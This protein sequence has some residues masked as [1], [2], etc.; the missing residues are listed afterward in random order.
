MQV[1]DPGSPTG[2]F[3]YRDPPLDLPLDLSPLDRSARHVLFATPECAPLTKTGGL[4]DVSEAL[5]AALRRIGIDVRVLLPG[6]E[7]VLRKIG[8]VTPSVSGRFFGHDW[9]ILESALP[10]AVPLY[11]LDSPGL[12]ARAG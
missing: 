4:G 5:P 12:Y 1:S 2:V 6:Y 3:F 10:S 8:Q 9:R 11:L 7:E